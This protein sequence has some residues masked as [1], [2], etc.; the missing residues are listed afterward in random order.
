MSLVV[1]VDHW[2]F[3]SGHSSRVFFVASFLFL[4]GGAGD[5]VVAAVFV[6]AAATAAS[7]VLMGRHFVMDVVAGAG[8]GAVEGVITHRFLKF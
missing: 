8:L 7:R 2:S 1:A 3:P 6:W 4:V 5:G